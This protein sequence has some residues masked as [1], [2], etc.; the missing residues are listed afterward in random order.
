MPFEEE[1]NCVQ[2]YKCE[3]WFHD[4]CTDMSKGD[5]RAVRQKNTAVSW[6]CLT[7]KQ[8]PYSRTSS[9]SDSSFKT[10]VGSPLHFR[11]D[12]LHKK[13]DSIL[14]SLSNFSDRINN[15]ESKLDKNV[16]EVSERIQCS[17]ANISLVDKKLEDGLAVLHE[18]INSVTYKNP[19]SKQQAVESDA[20]FIKLAERVESMERTNRRCDLLID[21]LP[22][23]MPYSSD[24]GIQ[25]VMAVVAHYKLAL[26]PSDFVCCNRLRRSGAATRGKP[27]SILVRFKQQRDRD[28]FYSAYL[29]KRD[30]TLHQ[31]IPSMEVTSRVYISESLTPA[32]RILVRRCAVLRK[33]SVISR[34]H[35]KQGR[36]FIQRVPE[37][38]LILVYPGLLDEIENAE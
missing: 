20:N 29:K 7:C 28:D 38:P 27:E 22:V 35:T 36:L 33:N 16:A 4:D 31:V 2:C 23:Q 6:F 32:C 8:K 13:I 15:V 5:L 19:F 11:D 34:Y 24:E 17:E 3:I 37:G 1:S 12:D 10:L 26:L 14:E 21:G 25:I 18:R 9:E 30:L